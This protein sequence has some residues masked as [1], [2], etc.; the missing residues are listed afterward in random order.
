MTK[1]EINPKA[2]LLARLTEEDLPH[3]ANF[4]CGDTEMNQFLKEES[5]EEQKRGL[6]STILLYYK[7]EL[8]AFCSICCDSITLSPEERETAG[9]LPPYKNP[10]IKLAR[11]GRDIQY[12]KYGFGEKPVDY[13]KDLALNLCESQLGVRF[14]TVDA[15]CN[16]VDFYRNLDFTENQRLQTNKRSTVSMRADIFD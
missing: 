2:I 8:A 7:G 10:A 4:N 3:L 5:F 13:V 12:K 1:T 14:I 16:K 11:L 9:Q 15:Y 6:N